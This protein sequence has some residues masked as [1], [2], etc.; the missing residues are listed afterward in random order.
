V[1]PHTLA[2]YRDTTTSEKIQDRTLFITRLHAARERRQGVQR[3]HFYLRLRI[4]RSPRCANR[5]WRARRVP[6]GRAPCS[7]QIWTSRIPR[8]SWA[9]LI[10]DNLRVDARN[11][12][13]QND[14]P[15]RREND[16]R[17]SRQIL[18]ALSQ[19]ISHSVRDR[20]D[21]HFWD[22]APLSHTAHMERPRRL[23]EKVSHRRRIGIQALEIL[24]IP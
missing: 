23:V 7:P 17:S 9:Y 6:P 8:S 15:T 21:C 12:R 14:G 19:S 5:V 4:P 24:L 11:S 1:S 2:S 10:A 16:V 18:P 22:S 20:T 13:G 3:S